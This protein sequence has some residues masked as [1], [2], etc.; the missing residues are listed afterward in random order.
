MDREEETEMK[1]SSN[2]SWYGVL[3]DLR[4]R[5]IH[6]ICYLIYCNAHKVYTISFPSYIADPKVGYREILWQSGFRHSC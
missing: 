5:K 1:V 2:E 6:S 4:K 3:S